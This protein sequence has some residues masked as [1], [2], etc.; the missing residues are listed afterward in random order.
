MNYQPDVEK[1]MLFFNELEFR[2]MAEQFDAIFKKE[3]Q[4]LTLLTK[5]LNYTKALN[6]KEEQFDLLQVLYLMTLQMKH[7]TLLN[8]LENTEHSYQIIQ[9]DLGVKLLLQN[10][11]KQE[12][13]CFDTETT[14]LDALRNLSVFHF[15]S[16]RKRILCSF[17]EK[18]LAF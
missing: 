3:P 13:V 4:Q 1:Q 9:G 11:L 2:R 8:T 14:G 12:S 6:R 17:P 10:L 18:Q 16:K 5:K 15:H 7:T